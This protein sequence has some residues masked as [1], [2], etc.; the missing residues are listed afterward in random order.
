MSFSSAQW[1]IPEACVWI[2][3]GSRDAVNALPPEARKALRYA[4]LIH[5]GAFAA[6]DVVIEAAQEGAVTITGSREVGNGQIDRVRTT[7]TGEFW[8]NAQIEDEGSWQ[9]PGSYWCVAQL[10][11]QPSSAE[12]FH[13]LLVDSARAKALS[14]SQTS[15][16]DQS[17]ATPR[18]DESSEVSLAP[19]EFLAWAR[20]E[21][22]EGRPI[23]ENGAK[24]AM[25]IG[26]GREPGRN[27]LRR[28]L[29]TLDP[30][31]RAVRGTPPA[32]IQ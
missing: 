23:T 28:W 26:M 30:S 20:I 12:K 32:K 15:N 31:W 5:P 1:T 13:D 17:A 18:T 25:T 10:V 21:N 19:R 2:V 22:A 6:R 4:E 7:L 14:T 16:G 9:S 11:D 24:R 27:E 8:R 3:T 29:E